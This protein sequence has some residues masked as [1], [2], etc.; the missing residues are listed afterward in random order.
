VSVNKV[1][2]TFDDDLSASIYY[3]RLAL[4]FGVYGRTVMSKIVETIE[5]QIR[6]QKEKLDQLKARK[7]AIEARAKA[8]EA[9]KNRANDTRKKI[10][11]GAAV[12]AQIENNPEGQERTKQ[13]L[14]KFLTKESDRK[15]FGL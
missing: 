14:D 15:L 9:K 3:G 13:M 6:K 11:V 4:Y 8:S 10:L 7:T 2:S 12:L 1:Y 5:E